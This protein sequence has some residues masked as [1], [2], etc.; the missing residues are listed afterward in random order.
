M[1]PTLIDPVH[2][3]E[4]VLDSREVEI[5]SQLE[6]EFERLKYI[7]HLGYAS[8][9]FRTANYSKY[10]HLMG[11]IHIFHVESSLTKNIFP[12]ELT[13]V[14]TAVLFGS[15][16]GHLPY[17]HC[18]EKAVLLAC[19]ISP[20]LKA[21][22]TTRLQ[23]LDSSYGECRRCT[24]KECESRELNTITPQI[25]DLFQTDDWVHLHRWFGALKLLSTD[26]VERILRDGWSSEEL[27]KIL[28]QPDCR[29]HQLLDRLDMLDYI[30][31]DSLYATTTHFDFNLDSIIEL[32]DI[33]SSPEWR[34]LRTCKAFLADK[35]YCDPVV[36]IRSSLLQKMIAKEL[37]PDTKKGLEISQLEGPF[38][39]DDF[40]KQHL[41]KKADYSIVFGTTD[42]FRKH[43]TIPVVVPGLESDREIESYVSGYKKNILGY[44]N[45]CDVL[46]IPCEKQHSI[47][48]TPRRNEYG[49]S[50]NYAYFLSRV[51]RIA[52]TY[53]FYDDVAVRH[54]IYEY[55]M[56]MEIAFGDASL[57][58][59]L[60]ETTVDLVDDA[61]KVVK[62]LNTKV[63]TALKQIPMGKEDRELSIKAGDIELPLVAS[64]ISFTNL[65]FRW[66]FVKLGLKSTDTSRNQDALRILWQ[67]ILHNA[68]IHHRKP[69]EGL[70]S[71]LATARQRLETIV[72]NDELDVDRR[73]KALEGLALIDVLIDED[74]N[75][76]P[77]FWSADNSVRLLDPSAS[78][79]IGEVDVMEVRLFNTKNAEVRI[80]SCTISGASRKRIDDSTKR[81]RTAEWIRRRFSGLRVDVQNEY[82]LENGSVVRVRG[83][84]R[85]S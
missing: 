71:L 50:P 10:D 35:I 5:H 3:T 75:D 77:L 76:I 51:H 79:E 37:I 6:S 31:R 60:A 29:W 85:L 54:A 14:M 20:E 40:I 64:V 45:V 69:S 8:E 72:L 12:V 38:G 68:T 34:F 16:I 32:A 21:D 17:S 23:A 9:V 48:L 18:G 39:T 1:F 49:P 11:L 65:A 28:V 46:M 66:E 2:N 55:L 26:G 78:N 80:W 59:L 24:R 15:H 82:Y 63:V 53:P 56:G 73:S 41:R 42:E 19:D 61:S 47:L 57:V 67:E 13:N 52:K 33:D 62:Q 44:H 30:L 74:R 70:K 83:G 4:V 84:T 43:W 27:V 22:I 7:K 36:E 58:N 25:E 81:N